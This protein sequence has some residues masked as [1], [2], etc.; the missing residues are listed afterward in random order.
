MEEGSLREFA[1]EDEKMEEELD[2]W[3][4]SESIKTYCKM[5]CREENKITHRDS[6]DER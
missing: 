5:Y 4:T 1:Q 6:T 2:P 3:T